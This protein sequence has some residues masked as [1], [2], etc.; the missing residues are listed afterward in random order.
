MRKY[1]FIAKQVEFIVEHTGILKSKTSHLT[2]RGCYDYNNLVL[3][4]FKRCSMVGFLD[5][6]KEILEEGLLFQYNG[7]AA[8]HS[9]LKHIF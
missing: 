1:E 5:L 2:T 6:S 4:T 8:V 9:G 7:G 3:I